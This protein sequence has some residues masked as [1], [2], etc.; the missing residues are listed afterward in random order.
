MSAPT[1]RTVRPG[2]W[3]LRM[4]R[5]DPLSAASARPVTITFAV[6]M[7]ALAVLD[8]VVKFEQITSLPWLA[9]TMV[10]LFAVM[11]LLIDRTH[12]HRPAWSRASAS[13]LHVLLIVVMGASALSMAGANV[14]VRDDWAPLIVGISL[15][16]LTPYRSA[17]ELGVWTLIHTAVAAALGLAQASSAATPLPAPLFAIS[18]SVAVLIV[19]AAATAY[20]LSMNT[21]I[22]AW[23]RRAW[24]R[25]EAV[26]GEARRGVA[27]S[28]R[29]REI[30][31]VGRDALPVLSR[32]A[33]SG[34][35]TRADRDEAAE[36][37]SSIRVTLVE[38]SGRR[39][40][41][42]LA[43]DL[44]DRRP[45]LAVEVAVDDADDVAR[46][47]SLEQR[48]LIR[49]LVGAA[50][51]AGGTQSVHLAI[52]ASP[53]SHGLRAR[54]E[55]RGTEPAADVREALTPLIGV[56]RGLARQHRVVEANGALVIEFV[57]GH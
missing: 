29:Q 27:R 41:R 6:G 15:C 55:V 44:I 56:V 54:I 42:E 32:V 43:D 9:V 33:E 34:V 10:A 11:L 24:D 5:L 8:T 46:S 12:I 38:A 37:A 2:R 14:L 47:A 53:S 30:S 49:A 17:R 45:E 48:T 13:M 7:T 21:S 1:P 52:D 31:R 39:W 25:A 16:A 51:D 40:A 22:S 26:A 57:Y 19:G 50:M 23:E 18:G 3:A 28:V 35:V 20:A 4:D 36:R